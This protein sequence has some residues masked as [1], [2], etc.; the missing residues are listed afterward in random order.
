ML[1]LG[2]NPCGHSLAV[3][4]NDV[5]LQYG[6]VIVVVSGCE[7]C[8][9]K[10]YVPVFSPNWPVYCTAGSTAMHKNMPSPR[11]SAVQCNSTGYCLL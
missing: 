3:Q 5:D 8:P 1:S 9:A 4:D 10:Q 11:P 6:A 7:A 2:V